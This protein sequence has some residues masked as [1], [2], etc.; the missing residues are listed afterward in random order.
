MSNELENYQAH[1]CTV[2][3]Q[4]D[5]SPAN[6]WEAWD[7]QP[8][9]MAY[10]D[11]QS[12]YGDFPDLAALINKKWHKLKSQLHIDGQTLHTAQKIEARDCGITLTE[13]R[14]QVI[15]DLVNQ[16]QHPHSYNDAREQFDILSAIYEAH[17]ITCLNACRRGHSQGD[18]VRLFIALTPDWLKATGCKKADAD[19][20]LKSSA[21]LYAAW[22]FGDVYGYTVTD[23]N[24]D[25]VD[26]CWGFYGD[27]GLKDG[28]FEAESAAEHHSQSEAARRVKLPNDPVVIR[29]MVDAGHRVIAGPEGGDVVE[30]DNKGQYLIRC[31]VNDYCISLTSHDG[32]QL[33]SRV[34]Y[35]LPKEA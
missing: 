13:A 32:K 10:S 19:K 14:E 2:S 16:V 30:K 11:H 9:L 25:D 27:E 35:Y 21:D 6:P 4:Y 3:I 18:F 17:G 31:L 20:I 12:T 23:K 1:G 7:S 34:F 29:A 24:G 8:P 5:D 22:A 28:K 33:N 26:S 15:D